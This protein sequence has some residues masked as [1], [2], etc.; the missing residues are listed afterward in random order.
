[1]SICLSS[2]NVISIYLYGW[3]NTDSVG[4]VVCFESVKNAYFTSVTTLMFFRIKMSQVVNTDGNAPRRTSEGEDN[5]EDP[6]IIDEDK[7]NEGNNKEGTHTS[8]GTQEISG[9]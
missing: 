1:M 2:Y 8:I 3:P 4:S 9:V 5:D 6:L 7:P